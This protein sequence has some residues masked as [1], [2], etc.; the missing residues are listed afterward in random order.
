MTYQLNEDLWL[1]WQFDVPERQKG[2]VQAF[3][4]SGS[5]YESARFKLH[6]LDADKE[7]AITDLDTNSVTRKQG[8]EL[9]EQ[10]LALEIVKQPGAALLAYRVEETV[11]EPRPSVS[12]PARRPEGAARQ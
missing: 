12:L 7:Y 8:R 5:S 3:R 4:R 1:A 9:M 10:G 2:I 6:G 11:A